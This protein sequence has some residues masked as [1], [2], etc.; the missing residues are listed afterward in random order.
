MV[1]RAEKIKL[2]E[3]QEAL[4]KKIIAAESSERRHHQR[5]RIIMESVQGMSYRK[6]SILLNINYGTVMQWTKKWRSN[7]EKLALL[8]SEESKKKYSD[9]V[10]SILS[11]E[12]RPGAPAKF[13]AEQVCK[14]VAMSCENPE[15]SGYPVSSW[16]LPL[17]VGE[18]VKRK[19]AE[20]ISTSQMCRF[21]K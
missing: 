14:I 3:R 15:D 19:I 6:I 8:E 18:T 20:S 1:K 13:T 16:S 12:E 17:L 4:L 10:L 5:A 11:D 2:S 21:L 7:A 9:A